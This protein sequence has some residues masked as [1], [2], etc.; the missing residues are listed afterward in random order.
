[1]TSAI[2]LKHPSSSHPP[3]CRSERANRL[4]LGELYAWTVALVGVAFWGNVMRN[5]GYNGATSLITFAQAVFAQGAF[6][7][8]AWIMVAIWSGAV[9]PGGAASRPQV[10][11]G[12]AIGLLCIIPSRQTTIAALLVVGVILAIPQGT[13]RGRQVA[14]LLFCI[15]AEMI[16]TS[17][18]LLP[19]H[20]AVAT[21]DARAVQAVL[22]LAGQN[23]SVHGNVVI[24][25]PAQFSI[26]VL[27]FCTSSYQLA[28]VGLA[29]VVTTLYCGRLPRLADLPWFV[30]A[31]FT[32]V[33]LT[34]LRLSLMVLGEANYVWIHDGDGGTVYI[35][36]AMGSAA[37]FPLL[38]AHRSRPMLQNVG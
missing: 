33:A 5:A 37:L 23:V 36:F 6:I 28:S 19:L 32:S 3:L 31:V 8:A 34:E 30:A 10:T 27:A 20:H 38:A 25:G 7:V 29:F 35:L 12:L 17:V 21:L 13:R 18:Y 11:V 24:N 2:H 16:W 4:A 15:A 26:E 1:M 22:S 9:A 14:A